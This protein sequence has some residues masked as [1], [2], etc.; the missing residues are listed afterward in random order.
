MHGI[1]IHIIKSN[2]YFSEAKFAFGHHYLK[3]HETFHEPTRRFFTNEVMR[4]PLYEIV[5]LKILVGRCWVFN[6]NIYF[7]GRPKNCNEDHVY[8]C[9]YRVDKSAHAFAKVPAKQK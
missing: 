2:Y 7:K 9:E 5:P 4:V 1:C 6:L 8:V 3:P